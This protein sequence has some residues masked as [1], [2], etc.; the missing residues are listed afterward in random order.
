MAV[1]NLTDPSQLAG[2]PVAVLAPG[3]VQVADVLADGTTVYALGAH[4]VR[5]HARRTSPS[6][7][8]SPTSG[9]TT[10]RDTCGSPPSTSAMAGPILLAQSTTR[11]SARWRGCGLV[12]FLVALVGVGLSAL[13]GLVVARA[14]LRP[15]GRLTAAAEDIARTGRPEPDRGRLRHQ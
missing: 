12:L 5:H 3:G 14:G 11:P 13:A 9:S 2:T 6:P 7:A 8:A 4:P 10:R 15:V 1:T